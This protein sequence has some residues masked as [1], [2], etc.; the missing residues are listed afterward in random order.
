[1]ALMMIV[2]GLPVLAQTPVIKAEECHYN[3]CKDGNNTYIRITELMREGEVY[4]P[5]HM[6]VPVGDRRETYPVYVVC[7]TAGAPSSITFAPGIKEVL[8][9][10]GYWMEKI[11]FEGKHTKV[12]FNFTIPDWFDSKFT[13][14]ISSGGDNRVWR[15]Q[16]FRVQQGH[17]HQYILQL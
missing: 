8:L 15:I 13:E 14:M 16:V 4:V 11:K 12:A 9:S 10:P 3:L 5:D 17:I 7:T 6:S 2:V 1:M